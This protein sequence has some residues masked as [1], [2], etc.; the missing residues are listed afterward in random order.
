MSSMFLVSH[1]QAL[2]CSSLLPV[3]YT[4]QDSFQRP[5][6]PPTISWSGYYCATQDIWSL[7]L[8]AEQFLQQIDPS[9]QRENQKVKTQFS[10]LET[11][12]LFI[13]A[14]YFQCGLLDREKVWHIN[15][16]THTKSIKWN[17][18]GLTWCDGELLT[19]QVRQAPCRPVLP[20]DTTCCAAAASPG[21][22]SVLVCI[23]N[24][25]PQNDFWLK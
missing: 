16:H 10:P 19:F 8:K 6:I 25:F 5:S 13:F 7:A 14:I 20:T 3:K 15:T 22:A 9:S 12:W 18:I 23:S 11:N 1:N 24:K 17:C 21:K 4:G 2:G